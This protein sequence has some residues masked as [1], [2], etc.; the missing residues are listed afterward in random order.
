MTCSTTTL[1][2]VVETPPHLTGLH[3]C[4][5]YMLDMNAQITAVTRLNRPESLSKHENRLPQT[6]SRIRLTLRMLANPQ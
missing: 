3:T 6:V 2:A 1:T 5:D 4:L